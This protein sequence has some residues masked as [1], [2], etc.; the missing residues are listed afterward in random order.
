MDI[1]ITGRR[2]ALPSILALFGG[3]AL[4]PSAAAQ[5]MDR[6]ATVSQRISEVQFT[7]KEY[8]VGKL[9]GDDTT[10]E[11]KFGWLPKSGDFLRLRVMDYIGDPDIMAIRQPAVIY[12]GKKVDSLAVLELNGP[13]T[14]TA[15]T[16]Y[17]PGSY[18]YWNIME[19]HVP[20][21]YY[22]RLRDNSSSSHAIPGKFFVSQPSMTSV[23]Q[24]M[25]DL[26]K[27][28]GELLGDEATRRTLLRNG[29]F[30]EVANQELLEQMQ[31]DVGEYLFVHEPTHVEQFKQWAH[32]NIKEMEVQARN[33]GVIFASNP[34]SV[35]S[36]HFRAGT[37]THTQEAN[38]IAIGQ[39]TNW[40]GHNDFSKLTADAARECANYS[41]RKHMEKLRAQGIL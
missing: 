32:F 15:T 10:L 8:Y 12:D 33:S 38:K 37:M 31:I 7:M 6:V 41:D 18:L 13:D 2:E 40:M 30:G 9:S 5:E 11:E 28:E 1:P 36:H 39:Y 17:G 4:T 35:V 27:Y 29:Y 19:V 34:L 14:C 26:Y 25:F 23:A 16:V 21:W 22:W 3:I 24:E 20:N